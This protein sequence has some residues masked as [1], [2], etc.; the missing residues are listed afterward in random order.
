MLWIGPQ[1][2]KNP[3]WQ[4]LP[5]SKRSPD[6]RIRTRPIRSD[7]FVLWR[8]SV[9]RENYSILSALIG[10]IVAARPAGIMAAKKEQMASAPAATVRA[11]GSQLVTP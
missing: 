9:F 6:W 11:S 2:Q 1:G 4:V 10:E 5:I 7:L 3:D 8:V